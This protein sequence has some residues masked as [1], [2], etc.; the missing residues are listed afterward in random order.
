MRDFEEIRKSPRLSVVK[1]MCEALGMF[2]AVITL[3]DKRGT[4]SGSCVIGMDEEGW[5]HVSVAPFGNRVPSWEDMCR[6]KDV[7]WGEEEEVL[8]IHPKKSEY[9]N[10]KE[11][12]LHLWKPKTRKALE[13]L[14][15]GCG[16][17][18]A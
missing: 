6:V 12:C 1:T 17:P 9:V 8:Q 18:R 3:P 5:E 7:F 2:S 10:I 15:D 4:W 14:G 16:V 11:N 13:E